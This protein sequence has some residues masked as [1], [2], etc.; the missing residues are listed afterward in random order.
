[1]YSILIVDDEVLTLDLLKDYIPWSELGITQLYFAEDGQT[2]LEIVAK[3]QPDFIITDIKM[4]HLNGVDFIRQVS[5][6]Y[7]TIQFLFLSAYSD[8]DHLLSAIKLHAVNFIEKPFTIEE[9]IHSLKKAIELKNSSALSE[10]S[11]PI[12]IRKTICQKMLAQPLSDLSLAKL[13]SRLHIDCQKTPYLCAFYSTLDPT[14]LTELVAP[15]P[16]VW[17]PVAENKYVFFYFNTGF[18]SYACR[19]YLVRTLFADQTYLLSFGDNLPIAD[20]QKSHSQAEQ[21]FELCFYAGKN[22]PVYLADNK[23]VFQKNNSLFS[24]QSPNTTV[25]HFVF[26]SLNHLILKNETDQLTAFW[27]Q[28]RKDYGFN[29]NLPVANLRH[30]FTEILIGYLKITEEYHLSD[31]LNQCNQGLNQIKTCTFEEG[32]LLLQKISHQMAAQL[33]PFKDTDYIA[34]K[35]DALLEQDYPN[36]ELSIGQLADFFKLTPSYICHLYKDSTGTTIINRLTDIRMKQAKQRLL[37]TTD[38]VYT[39][40]R[41]TGYKDAK[42][43][44]RVFEKHYNISPLNYRKQALNNDK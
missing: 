23:A 31:L 22:N 1:M 34:A 24:W 5:Q 36:P 37:T 7:P 3:Q 11:D 39:I 16:L 42:Y 8:K 21:L 13:V 40:A 28:F 25:P 4:P 17:M 12:T 35:I 10:L 33:N 32:L 9:V 29:L 27:K 41:L 18:S 44:S 30:A 26:D 19:D 14:P 15:L 6:A 38:K 20:Y 43:F 2:G